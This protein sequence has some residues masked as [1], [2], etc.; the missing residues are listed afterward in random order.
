[1]RKTSRVADQVR[2]AC[3]LRISKQFDGISRH[4][5][6]GVRLGHRK[7]V[8]HS[9]FSRSCASQKKPKR[10]QSEPILESEKARVTNTAEFDIW[11]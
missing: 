2:I 1:M 5:V 11:I 6:H 8:P 3:L 10:S 9:P 4:G 7:D